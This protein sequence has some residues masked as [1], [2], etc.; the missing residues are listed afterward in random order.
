MVRNLIH[1]E[2]VYQHSQKTFGLPKRKI[3]QLADQEDHE[4]RTLLDR[5]PSSQP[6]ALPEWKFVGIEPNRFKGQSDLVDH[7]LII[8]S[9]LT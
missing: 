8:H 3:E 1:S 9:L 4:E 2:V 6:V 7:D 5:G